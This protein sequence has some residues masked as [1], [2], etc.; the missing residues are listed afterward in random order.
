MEENFE[1]KESCHKLAFPELARRMEQKKS[2]YKKL[3]QG[4][5][6]SKLRKIGLTSVLKLYKRK[7]KFKLPNGGYLVKGD[8]SQLVRNGHKIQ[9]LCYDSNTF[10]MPLDEY[11]T[12][13]KD[14]VMIYFTEQFMNKSKDNSSFKIFNSVN[15]SKNNNPLGK[16]SQDHHSMSP[17]GTPNAISV[18]DINNE[19]YVRIY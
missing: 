4:I 9:K 2:S 7:E 16:L 19:I 17:H 10:V 5:D 3:L 6:D 18:K 13:N 12:A 14:S 8:V 1:F 11:Y 15:N